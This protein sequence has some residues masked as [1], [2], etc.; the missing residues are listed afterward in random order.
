MS[1]HRPQSIVFAVVVAAATVVGAGV[2]LVVLALAG[3]PS[4]VLLATA[5]AALPVGPLVA[6]FCWLDRYEPEPR[7]LLA[8]ALAWGAFVATMVAIVVQGIGGLLVGTGPVASMAIVAP[9]T[10]EATKGLFLLLLLW[11]RRDELDGVLDGIVYAGLVGVGFAFTE[12]ILYLAAA[13]DG[14]DGLGPGGLVGV[15]TTFV[16]RCLLSPFAHPLFTALTGIGIGLA[17]AS[18]TPAVR[19]LAPLGGYAAAV[20]AHAIWN[21]SAALGADSFALAYVVLMLPALVGVVVLVAW[22][23]HAERTL[24]SR[25]LEDAARRGL[26]PATD[27]GWVVDLRARRTARRH[28]RMHGGPAAARAMAEY[29]Q[30]VIEFGYL[31]HRVLRGTAPKDWQVRGR[32]YVARIDAVRPRLS[33]PGQVVPQG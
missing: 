9:V 32:R 26:L 24:L 16:V 1:T 30:S 25:A 31:H 12:N 15:T 22:L 11:W 17:V 13:H 29:Q 2:M 5:L 19:W 7:M 6:V 20:A 28:A 4:V 3:A 21:G 23:R 18:R 33:F 14:T 10:E 27:I 8:A